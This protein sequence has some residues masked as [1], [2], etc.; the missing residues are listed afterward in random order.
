MS[1]VRIDDTFDDNPK[2]EDL[3]DAAF[4]LYV[5]VL[6]WCS[7][8]TTDGHVTLTVARRRGTTK[9]IRELLDANLWREAPGGYDVNDFLTYNPSKAEVRARR[10]AVNGRVRRHRYKDDCNGVTDPA[11]TGVTDSVTDTPVTSPF[12]RGR[13]PVPSRPVPSQSPT[14][15]DQEPDRD[16]GRETICPLDLFD[17]AETIGL[18]AEL[19]EK[20][21]VPIE[22]IRAE[23]RDFV[24]YWTIGGGSGRRRAGWMRQLRERIRKRHSEGQLKAPG[25]I[26]HGH[27]ATSDD[28]AAF[29]RRVNRGEYGKRIQS[30]AGPGTTIADLRQLVRERAAS[31]Q[32]KP[33]ERELAAAGGIV[34]GLLDDVKPPDRE[35]A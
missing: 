26:E 17:K 30:A 1:W 18:H 2:V 8:H 7:R 9:T 25:L 23:T 14:T 22:S 32:V 33:P 4:R 6:C 11:Q 34:A 28:D 35:S 12:V 20:L 10:E 13:D 29:L 19:A 15:S 3:S 16:P 27:Q 24:S 31:L 5:T 21:A